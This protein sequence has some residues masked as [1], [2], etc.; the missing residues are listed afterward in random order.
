MPLHQEDSHRIALPPAHKAVGRPA[1]RRG[2]PSR[3]AGPAAGPQRLHQAGA[4]DTAEPEPGLL[5]L[6]PVPGRLQR[7]GALDMALPLAA[8]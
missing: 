3:A 7:G 6:R 4:H 5:L 8:E 2:L 1:R